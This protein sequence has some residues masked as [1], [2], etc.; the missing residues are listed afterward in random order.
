MLERQLVISEDF[1]QNHFL[2]DDHHGFLEGVE[3]IIIDKTQTSD[4][5]KREYYWMRIL[6][7]FY[8]DGLNFESDY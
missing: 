7:T 5:T 1:L 3:V 2:Q 4:P 8:P 6:K